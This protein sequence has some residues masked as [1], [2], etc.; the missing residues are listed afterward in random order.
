MPHLSRR[1]RASPTQVTDD[2]DRARRV[3]API[4]ARDDLLERHAKWPSGPHV[5]LA[6]DLALGRDVNRLVPLVEDR[7][8]EGVEGRQVL[9][10][11]VA[12][13]KLAPRRLDLFV[14]Q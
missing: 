5:E 8:D 14:F 4:D 12:P 1:R 13:G 9:A 2:D 11:K 7:S 10:R 3:P 6:R